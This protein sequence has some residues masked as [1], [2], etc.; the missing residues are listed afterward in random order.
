[1]KEKEPEYPAF[2]LRIE[3]DMK[4]DCSSI[5]NFVADF[6]YQANERINSGIME[7]FRERQE[8]FNEAVQG[9]EAYDKLYHC[10]SIEA[11]FSIIKNKSFR[12]SN[13]NRVNDC[14]EI[15]NINDA[16]LRDKVFIACFTYEN[17]ID[18]KH[19]EEY[20]ND[21]DG[22]LFSVKKEWFLK[23][24]SPL[25]NKDFTIYDSRDIAMNQISRDL[26]GSRNTEGPYYH[27]G[28]FDFLKVK[29]VDK[30]IGVQDVES[31]I[32]VTYL[33][34]AGIV[35]DREGVCS[36]PNKESYLKNWEEEKEIRLR[37]N[38]GTTGEQQVPFDR[39]EIELDK[40][41]FDEFEV[42]FA[43]SVDETR[44]IEVRNKLKELL[45]SSNIF[46]LK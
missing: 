39:V 42:R 5:E 35:K 24:V 32:S 36:R 26:I 15:K 3:D 45:P 12:L 30:K 40:T 11:L 41:A 6:I 34:Y 38:L 20:G 1:M 44:I 37:I 10:T 31:K 25:Q 27:I 22:V 8:I 43:P 4:F 16:R 2:T 13:L 46:Y 19:W 7:G 18:Q 33:Q 17:N 21:T 28:N 14:E 23:K 29:Y 9:A